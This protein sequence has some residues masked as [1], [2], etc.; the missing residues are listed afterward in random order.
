MRGF[1]DGKKIPYARSYDIAAV[2]PSKECKL[3][4]LMRET[5]VKNKK[6]A[7]LESAAGFPVI[8]CPGEDSNLHSVATART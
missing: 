2:P 5:G 4:D 7:G 3:P 8:W 1:T 6:P